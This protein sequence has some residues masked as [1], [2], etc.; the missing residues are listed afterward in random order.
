MKTR[1]IEAARKAG[2]KSASVSWGYND[3][4]LLMT[5]QPD[6]LFDHAHDISKITRLKSSFP[7]ELAPKDS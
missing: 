1:D 7:L 2:V 5:Y 4:S 6:Y 3:R